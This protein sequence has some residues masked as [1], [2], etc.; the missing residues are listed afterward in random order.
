MA[1]AGEVL[2][3]VIA[4]RLSDYCEREGIL[5][6]EECGFRPHRS[7][8]DMIFLVRRLQEL[9]RKKDTPLFMCFIVLIKAYASVD[10]TLLWTVLARFGIPSRMLAVIRQ[11]HDGMR[12]CVRLDDSEC[13]DVFDVEQ[14]LRQECV[15]APLLFNIFFTAVLRVAE[16]RIIGDAVIMECMVQLQRVKQKGGKREGRARAGRVDGQR[17]QEAAQTWWEKLYADDVGV[18]S[19]S[20]DGLGRMMTVIVTACA[21]FG[22]TVS[23]AKTEIMCLQTNGGGHVPFTVTA[24]GQVYKQTVEFVYLGGA[25]SCLLYTSPSPRDS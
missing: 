1:H 20:P 2:L 9:A 10:R 12:A 22:L 5:P 6:E 23:E 17:N 24:S 15:L 8:V 7:T 11:I 4:G 18:V 16:K 25:I 21:V 19:R 13:S 14:G 3:K